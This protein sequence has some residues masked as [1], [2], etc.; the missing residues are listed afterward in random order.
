MKGGEEL[1]ERARLYKEMESANLRSADTVIA[2]TEREREVIMKLAPD[3]D[4]RVIPNIHVVSEERESSLEHRAGLLFIGHYL[5]SPNTDAVEYFVRDILPLVKLRIPGVKFFIV[6]SAMTDELYRLADDSV[7]VIG[8]IPDL[9]PYF[10]QSRV[11]VAPLRFGAGMKGKIGQSMSMGLPVVT[12]SIG[13]EGMGLVNETHVLIADDA[14]TFADAVVRLYTDDDRWRVI[15]HQA[16]DLMQR[17]FSPA[18]VQRQ[19]EALLASARARSC[20]AA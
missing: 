11:F 2:I 16:R 1:E 4:I 14:P 13:A 10:R 7:K 18:S 9:T 5:H 6:G 20:S 12:T 17:E 8:Y 19:I 15:A 3:A